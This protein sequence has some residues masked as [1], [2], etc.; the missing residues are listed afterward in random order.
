MCSERK[1]H[2]KNTKNAG[3]YLPA[4]YGPKNWVYN[5]WH[6]MNGDLAEV[7]LALE[8]AS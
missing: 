8:S 1:K 3:Y 5:D 4:Q 2:A 7:A 6:S